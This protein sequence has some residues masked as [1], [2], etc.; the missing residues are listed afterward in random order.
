MAVS[1]AAYGASTIDWARLRAYAK[2]VAAQM[3]D[4]GDYWVLTVR[5]WNR[6]GKVGGGNTEDLSER[7]EYCLDRD[8]TLNV[9]VES[10]EVI[11]GPNGVT[12]YPPSTTIRPFMD[13]DVT[14]FDFAPLHRRL[15]GQFSGE[16]SRG[17][18]PNRL[19]RHAKG[20]GLSLALKELLEHPR[21]AATT[22]APAPAPTPAVAP[23][24]QPRTSPPPKKGWIARILG[25]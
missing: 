12:Q 24:A 9:R 19:L 15:R 6:V 1:R 13:D 7:W 10:R 16:D 25:Q 21:A 11:Y 18:D 4:G 8:G 17:P 23:Q 20:V 2:K 5:H 14:L 22:P 3:G